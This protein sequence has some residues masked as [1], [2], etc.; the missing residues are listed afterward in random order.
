MIL[1][2]KVDDLD[3]FSIGTRIQTVRIQR[4]IKAIDL[5]MA[6]E[7]TPDHMSKIENGR[8]RCSLLSLH[9]IAQ[10]LNVST[11]YLLY[12]KKTDEKRERLWISLQ[13]VNDEMLDL[14]TK[15]VNAMVT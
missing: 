4:D 15:V 6:L 11:D 9:K 10:H 2:D 3:W 8:V 5:A 12:G 13:G 14:V 1:K 7:I